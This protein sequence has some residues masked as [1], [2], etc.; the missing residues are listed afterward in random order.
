MRFD[1]KRSIIREDLFARLLISIGSQILLF[2]FFNFQ[3]ITELYL[4]IEFTRN[5]VLFMALFIVA[6]NREKKRINKWQK[7]TLLEASSQCRFF[8]SKKRKKEK[9]NVTT[10]RLSR[11]TFYN[12]GEDKSKIAGESKAGILLR[13]IR[14]RIETIIINLIKNESHFE[15]K[16]Q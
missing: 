11:I 13:K 12:H 1:R 6:G 2:R 3:N 10:M 9:K 15:E 14:S 5:V 4:L 8:L 16:S 7:N